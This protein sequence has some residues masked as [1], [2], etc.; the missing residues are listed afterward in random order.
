MKAKNLSVRIS[1]SIFG[2][3]LA[4]VAVGFLKLGAM[5]VDPFQV[6]MAGL[7]EVIPI[8]FGTLYAIFGLLLLAFSFLVQRRYV[9]LA[10]IITLTLQGYVIDFS[11]NM[12]FMLFPDAGLG[13][14]AI[15]FLIGILLLCFATAVYFA[16]DLGVS[17]YDAIALI[18]TNTFKK[19]K[20]RYN[21]ILT[22]CICLIV[23][24]AAFLLGGNSFYDLLA[25]VGIGTV[26]T[27]FCMGP[28]VDFFHTKLIQPLMRRITQ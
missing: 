12:L 27:A 16:A 4:G 14:R 3:V 21:R 28:L 24:S 17:A 2:V 11:K 6:L 18:I 25:V 15:S 1:F 19:G 23:G 8:S 5:G 20:F 22:D 10:S 7:N 9:G 26:V 13:V